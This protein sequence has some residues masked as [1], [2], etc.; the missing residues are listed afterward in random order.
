MSVIPNGYWYL[1]ILILQGC[2]SSHL[3]ISKKYATNIYTCQLPLLK[4]KPQ[5]NI[6]IQV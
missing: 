4:E 3:S 6:I 1:A 2:K 5:Q